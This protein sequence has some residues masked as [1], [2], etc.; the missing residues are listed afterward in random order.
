[1]CRFWNCVWL[2]LN[3]AIFGYTLGTFVLYNRHF[4]AQ[5]L[6]SSILPS[7]DAF[8]ASG[9]A[10]LDSWPAGLKLNTELSAFFHLVFLQISELFAQGVHA[11]A[12]MGIFSVVLGAFGAVGCWSVALML[13]LCMDAVTILTLNISVSYRISAAILRFQW[14]ALY[15]LFTLFRGAHVREWKSSWNA[16]LSLY[17]QAAERPQA[18]R[19]QLGVR[20]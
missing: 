8:V 9:L 5:Y 1:M 3:D 15:L 18:A 10:W 11:S 4:L 13:A 7:A 20:H 19:R 2:F 17:R 16:H 14:S 12:R 6:T